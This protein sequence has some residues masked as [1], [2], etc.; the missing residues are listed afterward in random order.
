MKFQKSRPPC[1][2]G[3]PLPSRTVGVWGC[4][5]ADRG[6]L[7]KVKEVAPL[8]Q[9]PPADRGNRKRKRKKEREREKKEKKREKIA[10]V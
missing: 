2:T 8:I 1:L 9:R 10:P 6:Q 3:D 5:I 7:E 4:K